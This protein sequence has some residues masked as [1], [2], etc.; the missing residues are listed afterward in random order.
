MRPSAQRGGKEAKKW[1]EE[2]G[3]EREQQRGTGDSRW[4]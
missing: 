4:E 1:K 2:G 3:R